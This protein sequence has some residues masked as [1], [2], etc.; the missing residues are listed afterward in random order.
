MPIKYNIDHERGLIRTV[1]SGYVTFA[2]V[3]EHFV[4]LRADASIPDG[5]DVLLDLSEVTSVPGT[6]QLRNVAAET[7][8]L[9]TII[10]WGLLAIVSSQPLLFA[11]GRMFEAFAEAYFEEI[12]VFYRLEDAEAW[13]GS[14]HGPAT[15]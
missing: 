11:M 10:R 3:L 9:R 15:S 14:K 2:E 12:R 6:E 5:L 1:C 7:G 13:L 4:N 8:K